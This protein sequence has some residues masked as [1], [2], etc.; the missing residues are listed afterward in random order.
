MMS[1]RRIF[2][3]YQD[4]GAFNSLV[5]VQ[6]VVDEHTWL[7]KSGQLL[8]VLAVHGV[9]DA[10]VDPAA[11]DHVARQFEASLRVFDERFR[12]YQYR[13]KGE[14]APASGRVA[15]HPAVQEA[16]RDRADFLADRDLHTL[17]TYFVVVFEG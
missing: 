4:A 7:T 17:N 10:C 14:P 16:L 9:D 5:N 12:L 1:L 6:S 8:S 13:L 3:D 15:R 11:R 2:K